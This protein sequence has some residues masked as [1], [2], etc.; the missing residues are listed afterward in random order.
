MPLRACFLA[1]G[2]REEDSATS[3]TSAGAAQEAA[4]SQA[5]EHKDDSCADRLP[6]VSL[7]ELGGQL[8]QS[9]HGND[10]CDQPAD[11]PPPPSRL[12]RKISSGL[13]SGAG[14]RG[15]LHHLVVARRF[16]CEIRWKER[17]IL[18]R[19]HS[20]PLFRGSLLRPYGLIVASPCRA[21]KRSSREA[22]QARRGAA[23]H[24]HLTAP[25]DQSN[26]NRTTQGPIPENALHCRAEARQNAQ[27][28]TPRASIAECGH[29][30]RAAEPARRGALGCPAL[31]I[32]PRG[33]QN[34][35]SGDELDARLLRV[36]CGPVAGAV[37][38]GDVAR[39][40]RPEVPRAREAV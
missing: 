40:R 21:G 12:R 15:A 31:H 17:I 34:A 36:K 14:C 38:A 11:P 29:P 19:A 23:R 8:H 35:G 32:R 10:Y 6:V 25:R 9:D 3:T 26:V 4:G 7:Y 22:T 28:R 2:H 37:V 33:Q 18:R 16:A 30:L 1:P 27:C 24:E 39:G 5:E 20:V 13:L